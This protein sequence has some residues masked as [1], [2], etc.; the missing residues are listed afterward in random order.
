MTRPHCVE[1]GA[2]VGARLRLGAYLQVTYEQA[3]EPFLQTDRLSDPE[4]AMLIGGACA[5]AYGW[6]PKKA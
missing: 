4:L 1:A 5:N 6:S 2:A 3:T